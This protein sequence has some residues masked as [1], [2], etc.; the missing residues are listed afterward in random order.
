MSLDVAVDDVVAVGVVQG[1]GHVPGDLDRL[2]DAELS[3]PVDAVP[4]RLTLDVGHD[5]VEEAVGLAGVEEGKDVGMLE[6]RRRLDLGEEALGA[7][8]G[9]ELLRSSA[10]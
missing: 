10:R 3:F 1:V 7:D 2:L 9:G 6:V 4:E 8:D 5:V